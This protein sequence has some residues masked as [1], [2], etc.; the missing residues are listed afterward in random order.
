LKWAGRAG[1]LGDKRKVCRNFV[2]N[3]FESIHSG[4]QKQDERRA[5]RLKS[6]AAM[7]AN[8]HVLDQVLFKCHEFSIDLYEKNFEARYISMFSGY[9]LLFYLLIFN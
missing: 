5:L 1:G 8:I 9:R 6:L 7:D 4:D 3:P 2:G